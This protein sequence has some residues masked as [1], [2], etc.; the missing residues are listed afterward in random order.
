MR[1]QF[2]QAEGQLQSGFTQNLRSLR[3]KSFIGQLVVW[4]LGV[5]LLF[6]ASFLSF[7]LPTA[8]RN[9]VLNFA[10]MWSVDY[11][12]RLPE[13]WRSLAVEKVDLSSPVKEVRFSTYV[14]LIPVAI[15]VGYVCGLPLALF[16]TV[17]YLVLGVIGPRIGLFP[18]ASGGG[19]EYW[20]E[21]GFGYLVGLVAGTWIA[22]RAVPAERTSWRQ[23]LAI[24]LGVC[25]IH[26]IGMSYFFGSSILILLLDGENAFL[27]WQPF[28]FEQIR[29]LTWYPLP[30]DLFFT[31]L[32]VGAGF[33][34]RWLVSTLTA[35]DIAFRNT[36]PR[37]DSRAGVLSESL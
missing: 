21:P 26:V 1:A 37:L 18:F 15:F 35:P 11:C 19:I 31:C 29:N 10:H 4:L 13:E 16:S 30:Y 32:L 14:P 8:T 24:A 28:L 36:R 5:E 27:R 20:R 25:S 12:E 7:S 33:P 3:R 2:E 17:S 34:F 22:A 9:N 6:F 23:L